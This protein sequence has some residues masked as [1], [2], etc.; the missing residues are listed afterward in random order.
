M[1]LNGRCR[2]VALPLCQRSLNQRLL[3]DRGLLVTRQ[4]KRP[5]DTIQSGTLGLR[6]LFSLEFA[7]GRALLTP[8]ALEAASKDDKL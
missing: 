5:R 3:A 7:R 4:Q 1:A 6:G 8:I 2:W